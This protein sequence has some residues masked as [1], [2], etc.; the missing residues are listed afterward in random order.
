[1]KTNLSNKYNENYVSKSEEETYLIAAKLAKK[2]KKNDIVVL[3]GDLG[4]GKT[5][6]VY[7]LAKYFG[8]ENQVSS[9]T[10]TIVNEYN[11]KKR[12]GFSNQ[13][14]KQINN[15]YHFDVYRLSNSEDFE[16]SVGLEYFENGLSI[17]EWGE[18]IQ[19]ILHENVI[20][21]SID[22]MDENENY[23]KISIKR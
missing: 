7:G 15:I 21:V 11:V 23:R 9:P 18:I 1:M 12:K 2:L 6:F 4:S 22:R 19:D 17:I 14:N 8:I 10:F 5:K 20:N 13:K 16:I 3:T